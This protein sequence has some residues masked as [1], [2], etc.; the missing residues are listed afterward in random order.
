MREAVKIEKS[1]LRYRL[2]QVR[3]WA[4][5]QLRDMRQSSLDQYKM[6]EDWIFVAQKTEMDA[7]E[8]MCMIIKDSIETETKIQSELRINFMD[9]T[10]DHGTLNYITP[11]PPKHAAHEVIKSERFTVDQIGS[12]VSELEVFEGI[13]VDGGSKVRVQFLYQFFKSRKN[14][15]IGF[16]AFRSAF[17]KVWEDMSLDCFMA[18]IRNLD[19]QSTGFICWRQMMTYFILMQSKVPSQQEAD[20]LTEVADGDGYIGNEAFVGAIF[21]FDKTE[22]TK[23]LDYHLPFERIRF[24]KKALF[25]VN[26]KAV[27]GKEGHQVRAATLVENLRLPAE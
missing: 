26:A 10:V 17:P 2:I 22:V 13:A 18:L 6:L 3:N 21:W 27:Q 14:A 23:D 4:L 11:P 25:R 24:I 20:K 1:I 7:V 8:E 5:Q 12:T 16:S 19:P 15:S 9:F